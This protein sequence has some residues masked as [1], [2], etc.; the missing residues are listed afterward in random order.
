MS[1]Q[2]WCRFD[3][4]FYSGSIAVQLELIGAVCGDLQQV[5]VKILDQDS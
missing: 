4:I 5:M 3:D 1:R 2:I